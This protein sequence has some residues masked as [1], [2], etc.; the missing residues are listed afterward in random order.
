MY[1]DFAPEKPH[2][3]FSLRRRVWLPVLASPSDVCRLVPKAN[4]SRADDALYNQWTV[5]YGTGGHN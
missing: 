5:G 1:D 2:E 3:P 4:T